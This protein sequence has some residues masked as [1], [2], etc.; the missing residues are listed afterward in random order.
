MMSDIENLSVSRRLSSRSDTLVNL[1]IG[2][3]KSAGCTRVVLSLDPPR[4]SPRDSLW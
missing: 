1:G 4:L 2:R 3:A